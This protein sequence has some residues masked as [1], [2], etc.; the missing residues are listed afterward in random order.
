MISRY[1]NTHLWLLLPFAVVMLGFAP[2]YWFALTDAPFRPMIT[3]GL[4]V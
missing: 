2:S 1:R 3:P 4:A